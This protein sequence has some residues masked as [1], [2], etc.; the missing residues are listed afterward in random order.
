MRLHNSK[1]TAMDREFHMEREEFCPL[2]SCSTCLR[3]GEAKQEM[4]FDARAVAVD[5]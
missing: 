3:R 5:H 2:S 1:H 4:K